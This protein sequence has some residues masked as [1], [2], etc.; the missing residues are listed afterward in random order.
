M[1]AGLSQC[2]SN[3]S[4]LHVRLRLDKLVWAL[5]QP[6]NWPAAGLGG[7]PVLRCRRKAGP[8]WVPCPVPWDPPPEPGPGRCSPGKCSMVDACGSPHKGTSS[9]LPPSPAQETATGSQEP[10]P[11][12]ASLGGCEFGF[13]LIVPEWNSGNQ[14]R[15]DPGAVPGVGQG[16]RTAPRSPKARG[17]AFDSSLN[18]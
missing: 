17:A 11:H 3:F 16:L 8:P 12:S 14:V 4:L 1:A 18:F 5:P 10:G 15:L 2:Y 9:F 13:L 6:Q 7:A